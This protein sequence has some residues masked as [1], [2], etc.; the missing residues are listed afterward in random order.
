MFWLM[1]GEHKSLWQGRYWGRSLRRLSTLCPESGN[2]GER[3]CSAGILF[4]SARDWSLRDV[5][6]HVQDRVPAQLTSV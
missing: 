3:G 5:T 1:V 4:N 2:G 6:I